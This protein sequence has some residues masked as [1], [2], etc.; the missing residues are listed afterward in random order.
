MSAIKLDVSDF[1]GLRGTHSYEFKKLNAIIAP[2]GSGKSSVLD[3]LRFALAGIEPDG[4]MIN[5]ASDRC[6]VRVTLPSGNNYTRMRYRT[7][8]AKYFCGEKTTTLAKMNEGLQKEFGG[9]PI[10]NAKLIASGELLAAISSKQFGE[11]VLSYMPET[12]TVDDILEALS[13]KTEYVEKTVRDNLPDGEFSIDAISAFHSTCVERRRVLKAKIKEMEVL[14]HSYSGVVTPDADADTILKRTEELRKKRDKQLIAIQKSEEYSRAMQAVENFRRT[15]QRMEQEIAAINCPPHTEDERRSAALTMEAHRATV[16]ASFSALKSAENNIAA[17]TKAV[18]NINRPVCPLSDKLVCTTDKTKVVGEMTNA[19]MAAK[20][21]YEFQ[22]AQLETARK[23][24]QEAEGLLR[25]I[26]R[27]LAEAKRRETLRAQLDNLMRSQPQLPPAPEKAQD[28]TALD[29]EIERCRQMLYSIGM[30]S[31]MEN[32]RKRCGEFCSMLEGYEYLANA[33]SP[34]GEVKRSIIEMYLREFETPCNEKAGK[35]FG[36]MRLKFAAEDGVTIYCDPDSSGR[37]I[38]FQSLSAGEKAAVTF[39]LATT[40]ASLSG[41]RIVIMDELSVLD[42][43]TFE[44]LL[45]A[46]EGAADEY[47]MAV[48]A[49]ADH[50]D[51]RRVIT[52]H[53]T[54]MVS[55]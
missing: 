50:D 27:D 31:R 55:V 34:N 16:T 13:S 21:E 29:A 8:S 32:V 40:L 47:D 1:R 28:I 38:T 9:I 42:S 6:A 23:K 24:V 14:L 48:F 51:A 3:A 11:L 41:F 52:S 39:L 12:M 54:N 4:E 17:L 37:Y 46:A 2:N 19:L 7:R 35:I 45:S 43:S 22:K 49:C 33:F 26:D 36:S 18:E 53:G 20:K 10:G 30:N 5:N 15:V 44:K 25:T